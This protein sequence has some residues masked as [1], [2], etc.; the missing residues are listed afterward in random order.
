MV[1]PSVSC[2]GVASG[3]VTVAMLSEYSPPYAARPSVAGPVAPVA[4]VG[5][6]GPTTP[7]IP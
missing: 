5:P 4:P 3:K 2:V 1:E 6:V 7:C